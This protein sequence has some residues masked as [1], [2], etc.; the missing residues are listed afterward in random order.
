MSLKNNSNISRNNVL[1]IFGLF[2]NL[3]V[4]SFYWNYF[5]A[6]KKSQKNIKSKWVRSSPPTETV[7]REDVMLSA[8]E[9]WSKYWTLFDFCA[10]KQSKHSYHI[11]LGWSCYYLQ[12]HLKKT[13]S[14][15]STKWILN[16]MCTCFNSE[17]L[18]QTLLRLNLFHFSLPES[19]S[20]SVLV[21]DA[22]CWRCWEKSILI[23]PLTFLLI[24][25]SILLKATHLSSCGSL[26]FF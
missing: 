5:P 7:K 14:S 19:S 6:K 23:C 2:A 24:S 1:V 3:S 4:N 10:H 22:A 18:S 13:L 25:D 8:V 21:R 9:K 11:F 26:R 16:Q 15:Q 17:A 12:H 20:I